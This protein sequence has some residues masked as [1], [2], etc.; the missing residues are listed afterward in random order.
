[1]L[2]LRPTGYAQHE[3]ELKSYEGLPFALSPPPSSGQATRSEVEGRRHLFSLHFKKDS[4]GVQHDQRLGQFIL[5]TPSLSP[6]PSSSR[7][8]IGPCALV[9]LAFWRVLEKKRGGAE[10][11]VRIWPFGGCVFDEDC[12]CTGLG[13]R[14]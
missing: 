3:R 12:E 1:M 6:N 5:M 11:K 4:Y 14:R 2:R 9:S 13:C 7:R 10:A 8:G